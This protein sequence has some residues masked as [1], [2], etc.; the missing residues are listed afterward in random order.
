MRG[1]EIFHHS[2][3]VGVSLSS[4]QKTQVCSADRPSVQTSLLSWLALSC[5]VACHAILNEGETLQTPRPLPVARCCD[6]SRRGRKH[7][8]RCFTVQ[9]SE[10]GRRKRRRRTST[11]EMAAARRLPSFL[12]NIKLGFIRSLAF[13]IYSTSPNPR[14]GFPGLFVILMHVR[15]AHCLLRTRM[16]MIGI[17]GCE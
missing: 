10:I 6:P 12:G 14:V 13:V 17:L 16:I 7:N 5:P 1:N 2:L 4:L 3:P 15:I 8:A 9:V 11:H